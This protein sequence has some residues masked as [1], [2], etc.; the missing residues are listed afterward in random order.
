MVRDT[1]NVENKIVLITGAGGGLG[2]ALVSQFAEAGYQVI[3]VDIDGQKL[4][5][6]K[7]NGSI[8]RKVLDVTNS[9]QIMALK[10]D[11]DLDHTG[12]DILIC[13]A[14]IYEFYPVTEA[15]PG[16]FQKMMSVNLHGTADLI[17]EMLEPLIKRQGRVVVVSSE[18][19]KIQALFQ[20]YMITKASLEA[21]CRVA[22]Q[23][24]A[25]KGVKL[26]L[27]RPGAINTPLLNWMTSQGS[28]EKYPVFKKELKAGWERSVKMVG[29][30]TP[31]EIV[32]SGIFKAATKS[33]PRR[34]YRINNSNLLKLVALVPLSVFDWLVARMFR[35]KN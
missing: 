24:L 4:A 5:R 27:I 13:A 32:A 22:R 10:K 21:Y 16:D 25:L 30:I 14:G 3:A 23:E 19:Y 9:A 11:L 29:K 35:I 26:T 28:W 34:V 33:K 7:S 18:S 31:P 6:L 17:R 2:S 20:P 15:I 8:N 12:L 1:N